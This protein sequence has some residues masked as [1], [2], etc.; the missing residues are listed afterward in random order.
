LELKDLAEQF[1]KKLS[2]TRHFD[3]PDKQYG[4]KV[5]SGNGSKGYVYPYL[6]EFV[7][8]LQEAKIVRSS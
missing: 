8:S 1:S 2:I 5:V 4:V 7:F 3:L 6:V